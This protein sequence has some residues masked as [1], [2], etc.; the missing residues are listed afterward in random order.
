[1]GS[2]NVSLLAIAL[3]NSLIQVLQKKQGQNSSFHGIF[4]GSFP[5]LQIQ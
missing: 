4:T 2:L 3:K 1:M 5:I